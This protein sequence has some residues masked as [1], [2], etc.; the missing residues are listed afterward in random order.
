MAWALRDHGGRREPEGSLD[1]AGQG[2]RGL[3]LEVRMDAPS[4][5]HPDRGAHRRTRPP[6]GGRGASVSP[7]S[8]CRSSRSTRPPRRPCASPTTA[9]P[10][11]PNGMSSFW[12]RSSRTSGRSTSTPRWWGSPTTTSTISSRRTPDTGGPVEPD[13]N[14]KPLSRRGDVWV[15]G[16]HRL[17]CGDPSDPKVVAKALDGAEPDLMVTDWGRSGGRR[18]GTG[19]RGVPRPR[20]LH[21]GRPDAVHRP[22]RGPARRRVRAAV[23]AGLGQGADDRSRQAIQDRA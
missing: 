23:P 4:R 21:L 10:R 6:R 20:G 5:S 15:A 12:V 11:G 16:R 13:P 2:A 7:R 22:L 17:V 8:R 19:D 3:D 1:G 14:A 18:P 9:S